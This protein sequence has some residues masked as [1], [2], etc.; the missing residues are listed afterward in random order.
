MIEINETTR[1]KK[2]IVYLNLFEAIPILHRY[3]AYQ[4]IRTGHKNMTISILY[5]HLH[6]LSLKDN[7]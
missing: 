5:I 3:K 7:C 1:K 4:K 2:Y 6:I